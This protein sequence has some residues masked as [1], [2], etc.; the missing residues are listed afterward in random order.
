MAKLVIN[1]GLYE[2]LRTHV[3]T[4]KV[5]K[6]YGYQNHEDFLK[7]VILFLNEKYNLAIDGYEFLTQSEENEYSMFNGYI[8]GHN[9]S[10]KEITVSFSDF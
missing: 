8:K 6:L 5:L 9:T 10:Y 4:G 7:R 2:K 3:E 1:K